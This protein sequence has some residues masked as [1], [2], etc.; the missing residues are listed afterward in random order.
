LVVLDTQSVHVAAGV[1]AATTGRDP[2]ERVPGRKRGLAVDVPGLVIAVVVL[3]ANTHDNTGH[4]GPS[5]AA[6][7]K[8]SLL[9]CSTVSQQPRFQ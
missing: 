4:L 6:Y 5:C 3:A 1:A 8:R 7:A 9:R 2:A